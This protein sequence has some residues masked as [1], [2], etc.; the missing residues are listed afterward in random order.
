MMKVAWIGIGVPIAGALVS[1]VL[2]FVCRG[3]TRLRRFSLAALVSPFASSVLILG[4]FILADTNPA[5][6]HGS[7][8]VPTGN[9]HDPTNGEVFFWLVSV[10]ATFLLS[11][12]VCLKVQKLLTGI[13]RRA[14]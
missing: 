12:F 1:L 11:A 14:G 2:F 9:E 8:Y 5:I 7:P 6:E 10:A 4:S 3:T 13:L